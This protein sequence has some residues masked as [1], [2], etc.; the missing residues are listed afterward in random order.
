M[1]IKMEWSNKMSK[2]VARKFQ[3]EVNFEGQIGELRIILQCLPN[4]SQ[5]H[6][7]NNFRPITI[8]ISDG[9]AKPLYYK[10]MC[11]G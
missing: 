7:T 1:I 9:A 5:K 2:L 4:A 10:D 3:C 11:G 8:T 6:N